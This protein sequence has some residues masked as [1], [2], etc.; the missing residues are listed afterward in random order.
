MITIT[1]AE[2]LYEF[3]YTKNNDKS[4]VVDFEC[5]LYNLDLVIDNADDFLRGII[6]DLAKDYAFYDIEEL[7]TS[8][9]GNKL[10]LIDCMEDSD[11]MLHY[12][13]A[14]YIDDIVEAMQ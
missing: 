3:I 11:K 9:D 10:V 5:A 4:F 12:N 8:Y 1:T 7:L 6:L 2:E 13:V 14:D